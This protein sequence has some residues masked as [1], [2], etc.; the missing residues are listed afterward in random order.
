MDFSSQPA[1][2]KH[3]QVHQEQPLNAEPSKAQLIRHPITPLHLH[4]ARNHG[5]IKSI[6]PAKHT[7][8]ITG[9]VTR[10]LELKLDDL[11]KYPR[12][13]V[14]AAL[15][16][17][18]N[19]RSTMQTR[20]GRDVVGIKWGEGAIAN[21]RWAGA[22]LR[23]VLRDAGVEQSDDSL[24][25]CLASHVTACEKDDWFGASIPLSKGL[26]I[27]GD[28]LI[29]YEI[30]GEPLPSGCG[31]PFR[32]VIPGYTGARWVKAVDT[33][34]V[35][36]C[37]SK[38][39]YQQRDYKVLPPCVSS[40]EQADVGGWWSKLPS[41]LSNSLNS[42]IA[43]VKETSSD[44]G[45]G[46]L[47]EG[48]ALGGATGGQVVSVECSVDGGKSWHPTT[49]TYSEGRWSWVLWRAFVPLGDD[50]PKDNG[51][52]R[53]H[54]RARDESGQ[55]QMPETDWNLRGVAYTAYGEALF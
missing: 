35:T 51:K 52:R 1:P 11:K 30:N 9:K 45:P 4:Y 27:N 12:A 5:P 15:Q 33:I 46:V 31:A 32:M 36:T 20:T 41:I 8:K 19:R 29:A 40:A 54:S 43:S 49:I 22:R 7:L 28:V 24:Y 44:T 10:E 21:S 25:L 3:L 2:S 48:Y 42:V 6:D 53:V 16:C 14:V 34:G 55:T 38:N 39:Y 13:E 37:E 50:V 47:V 18:G 17:A 26:D 23:D